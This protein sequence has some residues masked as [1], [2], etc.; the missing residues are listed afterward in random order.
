MVQHCSSLGFTGLGESEETTPEQKAGFG[1]AFWECFSTVFQG[2]ASSWGQVWRRGSCCYL[3]RV[4]TAP[5]DLLESPPAPRSPHLLAQQGGCP[6]A[7]FTSETVPRLSSS[8]QISP[9]QVRQM[10]SPPCCLA[11]CSSERALESFSPP[12]CVG[13]SDNPKRVGGRPGVELGRARAGLVSSVGPILPALP[14]PE[15]Q[16]C[17]CR[18]GQPRPDV[19]TTLGI[20]PAPPRTRGHREPC[21]ERLILS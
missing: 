20:S 4:L 16:G 14:L 19:P 10:P 6:R 7:I 21:T 13:V 11:V 8:H 3:L 5:W 1:N 9:W 18:R 15:A 17:P 2:D 12:G